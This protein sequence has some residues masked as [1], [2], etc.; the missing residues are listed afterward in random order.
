LHPLLSENGLNA[1]FVAAVLDRVPERADDSAIRLFRFI[2]DDSRFLEAAWALAAAPG[3]EKRHYERLK[4]WVSLAFPP[5]TSREEELHLSLAALSF[6]MGECG[7]ALQSLERVP[8]ERAVVTA[9]RALS[10]Q[11]AGRSEEARAVARRLRDEAPGPAAEHEKPF[12]AE[13]LELVGKE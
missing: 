13:A 10:L 6:R 1:P 11:G 9:L 4:R 7:N 2:A 8:Q 3:L 5:V 12:I